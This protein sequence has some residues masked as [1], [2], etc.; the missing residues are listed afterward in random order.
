M[1]GSVKP[2]RDSHRDVRNGILAGLAGGLVATWA[3]TEFQALWSRAVD[4][5]PPQSA[6]GRHDAREWQERNE[7]ENANE[8]VAQRIA[9][10]T[11]ERPLTREEL[12][13]AAPAV[14]YA[15]GVAMGALYGGLVEAAPQPVSAATGAAYGTLIWIGGDEIAVP[16]LG[17][18]DPDVEYPFEAHMQSWSAHIV[19]GVALELVRRRVRRLVM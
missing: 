2:A 10:Y 9:A 4:G 14:H 3:M 18:A 19:Y 12:S 15:F 16:L 11:V 6:G 5:A 1:A 8:A 13:I 7:D 17:L